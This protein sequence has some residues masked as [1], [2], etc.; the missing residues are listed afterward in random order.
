[1][2]QDVNPSALFFKHSVQ[3]YATLPVTVANVSKPPLLYVCRLC[4]VFTELTWNLSIK[5]KATWGKS[6]LMLLAYC[7]QII[8]NQRK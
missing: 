4:W 8:Q 6:F 5:S 2:Q 7:K 3:L 1:M